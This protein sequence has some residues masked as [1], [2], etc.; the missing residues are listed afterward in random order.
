MKK[1]SPFKLIACFLP[2]LLLI[3]SGCV[4]DSCKRE[5]PYS[6]FVPVYKTKDEVR[7]NIKSNAPRP[8]ENP[9]KIY[10][11]GNTIFLNEID[12]GIHVIDNSNPSNPRNVSFI[13][14][15]G[16]LDIA[17]KGTTL[18]ADLYTD[19]VAI[20]ISNPADAKLKKVIESQFP[21]RAWGGGFTA[22]P[23]NMIITEWV[24]K[25]TVVFEDCS[26]PSY[27]RF[28]LDWGGVVFFSASSLASGGGNSSQSASPVGTGGSMA[29]FTIIN[30]R[31]YTVNQNDLGVFNITTPNN[32][33]QS[34]RIGITNVATIETIFPFKNKLF[35]GSMAGMFIYDISN[36][37][38]PQ[39]N[40]SFNHARSCDPVIADD[41]YAYVTLRSGTICQGFTNQLDIVNIANINAPVLSRTYQMTNP[42][43]L[44]KTGNLLFICDGKAGLKLYN[45]S[46]VQDL[47]LI[48]TISGMETYDVIAFNNWALVVAKE[49]LYQYDYSNLSN[50]RELSKIPV[51]GK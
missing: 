7:N 4:K 28:F 3:F 36:P 11:L 33:Q 6:Y 10:I 19:L 16:N 34:N 37:D 23:A 20:D 2:A 45:A 48:K 43:G 32:P 8:V 12:K 50:I 29:R 30:D 44:S 15:P 14:I 1:Y 35:I 24:K 40:G 51:A 21:H 17:V 38:A 31:L 13:D 25:D 5:H 47:Q 26:D 22:N 27:G 42:H 9:G 49:G 39:A 41:N 46:N 18:Y